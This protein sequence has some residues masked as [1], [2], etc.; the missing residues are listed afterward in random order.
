MLDAFGAT[1]PLA[2]V[3]LFLDK[4]Q[5]ARTT[6]TSSGAGLWTATIPTDL[7]TDE[8]FHAVKAMFEL[9][10]PGTQSKSGYSQAVNFYVGLRDARAPGTG[11]LNGDVKVNLVD[12]SILLFHWNT[13]HPIADLNGDGKVNLTDFSILLFNWTG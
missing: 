13:D 3:S 4:E 10:G 6:A 7:V 5:T 2:K 11:D 12:F 9:F 1:A 8:A